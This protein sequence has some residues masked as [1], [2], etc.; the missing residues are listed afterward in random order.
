MLDQKERFAFGRN[1]EK[2]IRKHMSEERVSVAKQHLI[3]FLKVPSLEGKY[4]LDIGCGSGLHSLAALRAGARKIV[5]FDYDAN[6]V[7]TTKYLRRA[8]GEPE[9]WIVMQGSILDDDLVSHLEPA[10]VVY[11]WGVLHHTG[12]MWHAMDN[13]ARLM[14]QGGAFYAALYDYDIQVSPPAEF[15]LDIKQRYNKCNAL[16]R[17]KMEA[18]YIWVFALDRKLW[19][20]PPLLRRIADYKSGRGMAFYTD[21]VDW[22]GGWPM[23]FAKR[24]DVKN[25]A[26]KKDLLICN[27]K[28]GEANTEYLFRRK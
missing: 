26:E 7:N 1:W 3:G 6:C 12:A 16:G 25:W 2:F 28:T 24:E 9:C 4:F 20:L 18:W 19:N 11:S 5:S 27:M 14:K 22:L 23:E 10:D 8:A 13:A 21:V 15:W 17:R